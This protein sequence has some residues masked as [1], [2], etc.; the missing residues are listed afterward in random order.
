MVWGLFGL[1]PTSPGFA[2]FDFQPQAGSLTSATVRV[3]TLSGYINATLVQIPKKHI[4]VTLQAPAGT[5]ATVCLPKLGLTSSTLLVDGKETKGYDRRDYV[6]VAGIG[7][8]DKPRVV[9][10]GLKIADE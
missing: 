7:S 2:T 6:C 5:L 1:K 10:R 9:S 4:T 8:G 3:P